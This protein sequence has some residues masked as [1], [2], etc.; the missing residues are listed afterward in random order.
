[1]EGLQKEFIS[2]KTEHQVY[3]EDQNHCCLCGSKLT[4]EHKVDYLVMQVREDA[5]CP[6]CH[7]RLK[8]KSHVLQ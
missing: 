1:M 7:I 6:T 2:E 8:T 4:F 3:I 5:D